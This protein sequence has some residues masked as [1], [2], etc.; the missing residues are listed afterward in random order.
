MNGVGPIRE[1]F[2]SFQRLSTYLPTS[3]PCWA[4]T[5]SR[6]TQRRQLFDVRVVVWWI[7]CL[8]FGSFCTG[9]VHRATPKP[10]LT[11]VGQRTSR[12]ALAPR[13]SKELCQKKA[14]AVLLQIMDAAIIWYLLSCQ[15]C[16]FSR[17]CMES[18]EHLFN[19][20]GRLSCQGCNSILPFLLLFQ[21]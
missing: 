7:C 21:I 11:L 5:Q 17:Y 2:S 4:S 14:N 12:A 3:S 15:T 18:S 16:L 20:W 9:A 10:S 13:P 19:T 8:G 1:W 6:G